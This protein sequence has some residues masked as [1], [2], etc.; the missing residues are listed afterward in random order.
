MTTKQ[1]INTIAG[2]HVALLNRCE[3]VNADALRLLALVFDLAQ[4][5]LHGRWDTRLAHHGIF[6]LELFVEHVV[7]RRLDAVNSSKRAERYI[8]NVVL[9]DVCRLET[10]MELLKHMMGKIPLTESQ[11][12]LG[13]RIG[14]SIR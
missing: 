10:N 2:N 12:A 4:L 9:E 11:N 13:Y 14:N 5:T 6:K 8:Q 3:T 1:W 7:R